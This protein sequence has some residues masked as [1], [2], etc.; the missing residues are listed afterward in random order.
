M[1]NKYGVMVELNW[2]EKTEGFWGNLSQ[3]HFVHHKSHRD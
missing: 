3:C 2:Q 1:K